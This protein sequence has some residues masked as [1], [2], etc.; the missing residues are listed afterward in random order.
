MPRAKPNLRVRANIRTITDGVKE[1]AVALYVGN[2]KRIARTI[3]RVARGVGAKHKYDVR[4]HSALS[5]FESY[6]SPADVVKAIISLRSIAAKKRKKAG[7]KSRKKGRQPKVF[8]YFEGDHWRH[9]EFKLMAKFSRR[10]NFLYMAGFLSRPPP[11]LSQFKHVYIW[12]GSELTIRGSPPY[13]RSAFVHYDVAH[14]DFFIDD[15]NPPSEHS[16]S[17]KDRAVGGV[18]EWDPADT[19]LHA[20]PPQIASP[21]YHPRILDRSLPR[22]NQRYKLKKRDNAMYPMAGDS[23]SA[24]A[25]WNRE[26]RTRKP[27]AGVSSE[28]WFAFHPD[29]QCYPKRL[30]GGDGMSSVITR[31]HPV[32][33]EIVNLS[34]KDVSSTYVSRLRGYAQSS[35][36]TIKDL[37]KEVDSHTRKEAFTNKKRKKWW[38]FRRMK[39]GIIILLVVLLI[40]YI[41]YRSSGTENSVVGTTSGI[42][43]TGAGLGWKGAKTI[44]KGFGKLTDY[45]AGR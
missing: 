42:I 12:P 10:Y 4:G 22:A 32:I 45:A 29:S 7:K 27:P 38:T 9:G 40:V 5:G 37:E 25:K 24:Y 17:S 1:G 21:V 41:W 35:G 16:E 28:L 30:Y 3:A 2:Q 19:F 11:K 20:P 33:W 26:F 15:P 14:N 44:G 34:D 39:W 18:Q 6:G 23:L 31:D 8:V 13:S 36:Y 43:V